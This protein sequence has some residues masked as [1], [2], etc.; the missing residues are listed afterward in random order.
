MI[1]LI[2]FL[3]GRGTSGLSSISGR[4]CLQSAST[5]LCKRPH[6]RSTEQVRGCLHCLIKD[7]TSVPS[8]N[9]RIYEFWVR[10]FLTI[11]TLT[12]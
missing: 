4:V 2:L 5:P 7:V 10:C 3:F 6:R 11:E 12:N 9:L 1:Y 8:D